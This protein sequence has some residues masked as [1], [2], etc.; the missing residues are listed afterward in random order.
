M[1]EKKQFWIKMIM[2]LLFSLILPCIYLTIRFNLFA[3]TTTIKITLW[4]IIL[5]AII[6]T[7]C[8]VMLKY[9]LAGMKAKY[10]LLKQ[11]V[12]GLIKVILPLTII[13][14]GA[15]YFRGRIDVIAVNI[16]VFIEALIVIIC[17]EAVAIVVNPL[18][19]WA[20]ENNVEGIGEILDKVL[21]K[22]ETE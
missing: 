8:V 15:I 21:K 9:W 19:K 4:A 20:F 2:F 12:M 11:I 5:I 13:L 16:K 3:Q 22:G 1:N 6:I 10:S 14:L 17:C 18:P 7:T